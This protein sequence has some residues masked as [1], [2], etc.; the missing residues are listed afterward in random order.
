MAHAAEQHR[1]IGRPDDDVVAAEIA[2]QHLNAFD[3]AAG[4]E[5]RIAG[6]GDRRVEDRDVGGIVVDGDDQLGA[7]DRVPGDEM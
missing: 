6:A 4:A 1:Q 5:K 7:V 2:L 3:A